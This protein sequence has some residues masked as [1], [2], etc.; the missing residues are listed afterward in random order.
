MIAGEGFF[1][2]W[3]MPVA[4]AAPLVDGQV[5]RHGFV[6]APGGLF[7]RYD[8]HLA[9]NLARH[10][11]FLTSPGFLITAFVVG[12]VA[13]FVERFFLHEL[14]RTLRTDRRTQA[15]FHAAF[16]FAAVGVFQPLLLYS[17]LMCFVGGLLVLLSDTARA[18]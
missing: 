17:A 8:Q 9:L 12:V 16:L 1:R 10:M 13:V 3:L 18:V 15:L 5:V 11:E 7:Q 2:P 14:R 4:L 6:W